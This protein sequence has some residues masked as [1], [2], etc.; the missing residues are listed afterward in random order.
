MGLVV[1]LKTIS[2]PS[3]IILNITQLLGHTAEINISLCKVPIIMADIQDLQNGQIS[4][5]TMPTLS[6]LPLS[7]GARVLTDSV[8]KRSAIYRSQGF[9][10]AGWKDRLPNEHSIKR[11]TPAGERG[12]TGTQLAWRTTGA[13]SSVCAASR[14]TCHSFATGSL[15]LLHCAEHGFAPAEGVYFGQLLCVPELGCV[16]HCTTV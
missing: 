4:I 5:W 14:V 6:S 7:T 2:G 12:T 11:T 3:D 1:L 15:V 9:W 8:W 10:L 13:V 16:H